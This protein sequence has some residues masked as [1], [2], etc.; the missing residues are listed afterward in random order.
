MC[1]G[2]SSDGSEASLKS[3]KWVQLHTEQSFLAQQINNGQEAFILWLLFIPSAHSLVYSWP[4]LLRSAG[5]LS[6]YGRSNGPESGWIMIISDC[7]LYS[8]RSC[9]SVGAHPPH[10]L[11]DRSCFNPGASAV[12]YSIFILGAKNCRKFISRGWFM[13]PRRLHQ[14]NQNT[15]TTAM[16]ALNFCTCSCRNFNLVEKYCDEGEITAE[17]DSCSRSRCTCVHDHPSVFIFT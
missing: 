15:Y 2:L 13:D 1:F 4:Q 14:F 5:P 8:H 12:D 7:S 17:I 3:W 9:I 10:C 16:S 11:C 6:V